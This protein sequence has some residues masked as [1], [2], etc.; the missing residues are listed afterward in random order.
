MGVRRRAN[1]LMSFGWFGLVLNM[2][3]ACCGGSAK[4]VCEMNLTF[5]CPHSRS[6]NSAL[7]RL[8]TCG[9]GGSPEGA[10][11]TLLLFS[12]GL[13][14][15]GWLWGRARGRPIYV[16]QTASCNFNIHQC[17]HFD[18][19]SLQQLGMQGASLK[20]YQSQEFS[21]KQYDVCPP[22]LLTGVL[23]KGEIF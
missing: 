22:G 3:L 5:M 9:R 16:T 19:K 11:K 4:S 20:Y 18:L 15:R 14:T 21:K 6:K 2:G 23:Q 12:T 1:L 8:C 7:G 17:S 13:R 10:T